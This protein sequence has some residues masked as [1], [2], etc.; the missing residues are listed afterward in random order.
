[1]NAL[2]QRLA[3]QCSRAACDRALFRDLLAE[4]RRPSAYRLGHP[5]PP[6]TTRPPVWI[7]PLLPCA[8]QIKIQFRKSGKV[9]ESGR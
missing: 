8:A 9:A 5:S 3:L 7:R 1:L 4:E 2:S 6:Q